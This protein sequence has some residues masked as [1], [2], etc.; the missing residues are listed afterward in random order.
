[1][2]VVRVEGGN[3]EDG[4]GAEGVDA[5][6]RDALLPLVVDKPV[7]DEHVELAG[8]LFQAVEA[9]VETAHFRGAIRE[10]AGFTDVNVLFDWGAEK[11]GF[12]VNLTELKVHGDRNGEEHAE[13]GHANDRR[14]SLIIVEARALTTALGHEAGFEAGDFTL[15]VRLDLIDQRVVDDHAVGG[16]DHRLPT[17]H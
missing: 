17:Y 7:P 3:D 9:M 8:G 14:E 6:V 5:R 16:G 10:A 13:T 11:S 1:V 12:D 4:P 2:D 15:C